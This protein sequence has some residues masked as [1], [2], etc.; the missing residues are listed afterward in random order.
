MLKIV[1]GVDDDRQLLRRH[2]LGQ[3]IGQLRPTDATG[4]ATDY[5]NST[6]LVSGITFTCVIDSVSKSGWTYDAS[7][8]KQSSAS[9]K[10]P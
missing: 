5:S 1:A 3:T 9:V 8:N 6:T 4:K 10:A 7:A 2:Q